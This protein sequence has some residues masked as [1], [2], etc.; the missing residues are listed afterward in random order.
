MEQAT[1][2]G[3]LLQ[4]IAEKTGRHYGTVARWFYTNHD[5]LTRIDVLTVIAKHYGKKIKDITET[6]ER[7]EPI[8]A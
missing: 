7:E 3:R 6:V 4:E 5:Y 1:K 2:D 8:G